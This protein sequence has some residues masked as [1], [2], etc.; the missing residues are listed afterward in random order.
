MMPRF[1]ILI[2]SCLAMAVSPA[3]AEKFYVATD[4][5]DGDTSSKSRPFKTIQAAI[6]A[7]MR[8]KRGAA[9]TIFVGPG[10]YVLDRPITINVGS[11]S[12]TPLVLCAQ[13]PA[14]P[15]ILDG[16]GLPPV[17]DAKA[18]K[19]SVL[20][21]KGGNVSLEQL[22]ITRAP[23]HGILFE[24]VRP[25]RIRQ[26]GLSDIHG[27]GIRVVGGEEGAVED[28]QVEGV[29][30]TGIWVSGGDRAT[31]SASQAV[32]AGN[33]ITRVN[34]WKG[35]GS[36]GNGIFIEGVGITVRDNTITDSVEEP[37]TMG[38]RV[39]GNNNIVERNR[40]NHVAHADAGAIYIAGR[41]LARRG[42]IVRF[43][44]VE[45]CSNGVYLDDRASGNT[46]TGNIVLRAK[47]AYF[48]GGGQDN[49]VTRNVAS[50]CGAFLRMDNRGMGWT[51]HKHP[52]RDDYARLQTFLGN[53]S[54]KSLFLKTYPALGKVTEHDALKPS[55]NH[56]SENFAEAD[57]AAMHY[58]DM[59]KSLGG[60][61]QAEY[62]TWNKIDVPRSVTLPK[63]QPIELKVLEA[64]GVKTGEPGGKRNP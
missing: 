22:K 64:L 48:I 37:W 26:C 21:I 19:D 49:T 62:E 6:D 60:Q 45:D 58:Q 1:P 46:V 31:L 36:L 54:A 12:S 11:G 43:N 33:R 59:D 16:S 9:H 41:D 52:F 51:A 24:K 29:D 15:P 55:G 56:V 34:R 40:L 42:N 35:A 38:I 57:S 63:D 2:A 25:F 13:D 27:H 23:G 30:G 44:I 17:A 32:I 5:K 47:T 14:R 3:T 8:A 10:T 50:Q 39:S 4:G 18:T 20:T 61:H 53:G 28:C 7:A